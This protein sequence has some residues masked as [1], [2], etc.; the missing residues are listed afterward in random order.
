VLDDV[1]CA[2]LEA[3]RARFLEGGVRNAS[4][5]VRHSD[6]TLACVDGL[7]AIGH[8]VLRNVDRAVE[9]GTAVRGFVGAPELERASVAKLF[10]ARLERTLE[11]V[12]LRSW[13]P[14]ELAGLESWQRARV[15]NVRRVSWL[16]SGGEPIEQPPWRE[17]LVAPEPWQADVLLQ[18]IFEVGRTEPEVVREGAARGANVPGIMWRAS[19]CAAELVLDPHAPPVRGW[20]DAIFD[21][22]TPSTIEHWVRGMC[23]GMAHRPW[24]Q[25]IVTIEGIGS[26]HAFQTRTD[27]LSFV[28]SLVL[29]TVD[30]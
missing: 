14:V 28:D 29:A 11:G 8:A 27:V 19:C 24:E 10:E 1:R 7:L 21:P 6:Y 18:A 23:L 3:L 22:G 17:A 12:P 2:A 9:L 15:N 25:R 16:L 26:E 30:G 4:V 20:L 13:L 5:I